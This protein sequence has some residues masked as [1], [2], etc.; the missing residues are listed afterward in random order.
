[1]ARWFI[2]FIEGASSL[3]LNG[4]V[5]TDTHRGIHDDIH[6]GVYTFGVLVCGDHGSYNDFRIRNNYC[7]KARGIRNLE[8]LDRKQEVP[9][10][11]K[12]LFS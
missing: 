3:R 9:L 7:D 11:I 2:L 6:L 4:E 1:M 5:R 10:V 8:S 12:N